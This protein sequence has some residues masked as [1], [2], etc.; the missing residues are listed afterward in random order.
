MQ[1]VCSWAGRTKCH[2]WR[3]KRTSD[4]FYQQNMVSVSEYNRGWNSKKL[5]YRNLPIDVDQCWSNSY[6][7]SVYLSVIT[8]GISLTA[9]WKMDPGAVLGKCPVFL[10]SV[11]LNVPKPES[12][13]INRPLP[14][15]AQ[16]NRPL[17]RSRYFVF[18]AMVFN[19]A[20]FSEDY[21]WMTACDRTALAPMSSCSVL[22]SIEW[23]IFVFDFVCFRFSPPNFFLGFQFIGV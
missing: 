16:N 13:K 14:K 10:Q 8:G 17:W 18:W 11:V 20:M 22:S 19:V 7:G 21:P 4:G 3:K 6:T 9:A 15:V 23:N 12:C 5:K 2:P 1:R